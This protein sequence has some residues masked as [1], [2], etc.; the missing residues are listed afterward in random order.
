[1]WFTCR[2]G[3]PCVRFAAATP[4]LPDGCRDT[5][6]PV[7]P[8]GFGAVAVVAV[9]VVAGCGNGVAGGSAARAHRPATVSPGHESP[10]PSVSV[11]PAASPPRHRRWQ[12]V[13]DVDGDGRADT[14]WL[15]LPPAPGELA[16][17]GHYRLVARLSKLG[18]QTVRFTGDPFVRDL[19]Q[20]RQVLGGSDV[21]G[22]HRSEIFVEDG[23][24]A[25]V[26]IVTMFRL[27][28]DRLVQ[29]RLGNQPARFAVNGSVTHLDGIVCK[30]PWLITWS[31][32][33]TNDSRGYRQVIRRYSLSSSDLR[34]D[35]TKHRRVPGEHPGLSGPGFIG[36][37]GVREA[38]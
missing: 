17:P 19:R 3:P 11:K 7:K 18:V 25:S 6:P 14:A 32:A 4:A 26:G 10:S 16:V 35:A 5:I 36:C 13:G 30:P 34:L 31:D 24:G 2:L 22:D 27:I 28:A 1:M 12:P 38:W 29:V 9:A 15:L 37:S 33:E 21:D 23:N 20:Q 8:R